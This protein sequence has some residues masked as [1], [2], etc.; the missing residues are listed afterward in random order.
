M[1]PDLDAA[2][3]IHRYPR[4]EGHFCEEATGCNGSRADIRYDRYEAIFALQN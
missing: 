3:R 1:E 4:G 2:R